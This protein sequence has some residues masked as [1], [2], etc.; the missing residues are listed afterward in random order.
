MSLT[1]TKMRGVLSQ[2]KCLRK[3]PYFNAFTIAMCNMVN[4]EAV[5][6][7]ELLKWNHQVV[8]GGGHL[9]RLQLIKWNSRA[10]GCWKSEHLHYNQSH[11]GRR[12]VRPAINP[13]LSLFFRK[14]PVHKRNIVCITANFTANVKSTRISVYQLLRG[15]N[16]TSMRGPFL[17]HIPIVPPCLPDLPQNQDHI[18][19]VSE[20]CW[21]LGMQPSP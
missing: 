13:A 9:T 16:Q 3:T 6:F 20:L 10:Q 8:P 19:D 4:F 17:P 5:G 11:C 14:T 15:Y 1:V 21:M 12:G 2:Q 7:K 18:N